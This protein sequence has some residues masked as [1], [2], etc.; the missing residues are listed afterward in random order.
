[1]SGGEKSTVNELAHARVE[2]GCYDG[3][4]VL[5][6]GVGIFRCT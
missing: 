1:M 2:T 5:S 3:V 4:F 6:Y